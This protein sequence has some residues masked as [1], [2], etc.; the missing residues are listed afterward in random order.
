MSID[1]NVDHYTNKELEILFTLH[2]TYNTSQVERS[3]NNMYIGSH[4]WVPTTQLYKSI[5]YSKRINTC[6]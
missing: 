1:L 2:E 6:V 4:L 5:K 3:E